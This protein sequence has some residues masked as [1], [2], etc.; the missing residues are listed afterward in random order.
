M[1]IIAIGDI[2]GNSIWKDIVAS[3]T[4]DKVVFIGDY[5]DS[6]T[7]PY[8]QQIENFKEILDFKRSN[9]NK[10]VLL[11]GNHDYHYMNSVTETYSGYQ[12]LHRIDIGEVFKYCN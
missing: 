3:T 9:I 7:I 5:F 1:K 2:H 11:A 6:F 10:V 12:S 4:F 8:Q